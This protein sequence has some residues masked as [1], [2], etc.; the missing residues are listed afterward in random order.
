MHQ[1]G[2]IAQMALSA[3]N[4]THTRQT[5]HDNAKL[6]KHL[7]KGFDKYFCILSLYLHSILAFSLAIGSK[8]GTVH[9]NLRI[10]IG[11]M[12]LGFQ[13]N[14]FGSVPYICDF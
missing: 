13:V 7:K 8:L 12:V 14:K 9:T 4:A 11:M 6:R 5:M 1:A 10:D 2:V 3:P